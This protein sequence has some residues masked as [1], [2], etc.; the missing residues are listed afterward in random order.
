NIMPNIELSAV[1]AAKPFGGRI[2]PK[3]FQIVGDDQV[4]PRTSEVAKSAAY[5]SGLR[6]N[7][8]GAAL[9]KPGIPIPTGTD[10]WVAD[11]TS[12]VGG[13]PGASVTPRYS[14]P[15][16][17]YNFSDRASADSE[18]SVHFGSGSTHSSLDE[19]TANGIGKRET[20]G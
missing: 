9:L 2:G 3:L 17:I 19:Y 6:V 5:L 1:A 8:T 13:V 7:A 10:F 20:L 14:V 16:L 18:I 12:V 15:N 4:Q 11:S